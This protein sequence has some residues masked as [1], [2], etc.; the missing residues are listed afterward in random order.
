MSDNVIEAKK[1]TFVILLL[2]A[3]QFIHIL[4]FVIMM[5]LGPTLMD[6]FQINP[7]AF[8]KLVSSYNFSAAVMGILYSMVADIY[9]RKKLLIIIMIGFTVG[10][11]LCGLS[12]DANQMMLARIATGAFGGILNSLV[13]AI[14][15]DIISFERRGKALGII[16]SSFSIAS[17]L[18]V[19]IGLAIND[20]AGY[21]Y[22][23]YFIAVIGLL[24]IIPIFYILPSL[25]ANN[26][27]VKAFEVLINLKNNLVKT[28]HMVAYAFIMTISMSMFLLIPFLAPYAVK[29]MGIPKE[30][31]KYMYFCGGLFTVV[32]ARVFGVLTDKYGAIKMFLILTSLATVPVLLYTH[33][34]PMPFYFFLA[35]STFFMTIVSGR[36]IPGMTLI[37]SVPE[38]ESR[39]AF[40]AILN[41]LRSIGSAT[42]TYLG[43]L[44][45]IETQGGKLKFFDRTGYLSVF[46]ICL[47]LFLSVAV[48]KQREARLKAS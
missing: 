26:A 34:S 37:T 46:I 9:D 41:S 8:S 21:A 10:T 12:N 29:N 13:F 28:N 23:F 30:Y 1:E 17:V 31:L 38:P 16:M 2:A 39:G 33:A 19:P 24:I 3:V 36:M 40:M 43:G 42:A 25:K 22:P 6:Q 44:I 5:P 35:L 47:S 15:T 45:I 4:D 18:G 32:T 7:K 14:V 27:K 48:N 20:F 11:V